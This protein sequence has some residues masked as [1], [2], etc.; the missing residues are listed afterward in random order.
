MYAWLIS[1]FFLVNC[2]AEVAKR[3]IV[4]DQSIV[5]SCLADRG[6]FSVSIKI[7]LPPQC[8]Q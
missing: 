3:S 6:I 5:A 7:Y 1:F 2:R 8:D 4:V